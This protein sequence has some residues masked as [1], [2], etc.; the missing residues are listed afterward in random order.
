MSSPVKLSETSRGKYVAEVR[1]SND[2]THENGVKEIIITATDALKNTTS[3]S[4]KVE[5]KNPVDVNQDGKV[6]I[7][8]L[9]LVGKSYGKQDI[10]QGDDAWAA[11]VNG[12]KRV[13]IFDLWLVSKNF[14]K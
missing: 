14:G 3:Q 2:N 7:L 6:D 11:D 5:L 9:V 12:D 10:S 1:I 8:D 4:L 13:D